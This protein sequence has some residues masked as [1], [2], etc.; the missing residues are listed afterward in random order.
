[1]G[2]KSHYFTFDQIKLLVW[3]VEIIGV[4]KKFQTPEFEIPSARVFCGKV[5]K[6]TFDTP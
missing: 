4:W 3:K 2:E 5:I 6:A 1:M